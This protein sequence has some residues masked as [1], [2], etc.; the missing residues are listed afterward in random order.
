MF[1]S[2]GYIFLFIVFNLT[3]VFVKGTIPF[4]F[5]EKQHVRPLGISGLCAGEI[6]II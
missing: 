3:I 1:F 2:V 5:S 6:A 4:S